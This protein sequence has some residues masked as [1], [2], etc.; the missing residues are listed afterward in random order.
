MNILILLH[1]PDLVRSHMVSETFYYG[2]IVFNGMILYVMRS[3]NC[4][5]ALLDVIDLSKSKVAV[6]VKYMYT[7]I[8]F[9]ITLRG[10]I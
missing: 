10:Y 5:N 8:H 7:W 6:T 3:T 4:D 9:K 2:N 1:K